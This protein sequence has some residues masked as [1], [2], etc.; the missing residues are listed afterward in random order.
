MAELGAPA[1]AGPSPAVRRRACDQRGGT[2]VHQQKEAKVIVST[3]ITSPSRP[4]HGNAAIPVLKGVRE[5]HDGPGVA[6]PLSRPA[7]APASV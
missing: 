4:L 2:V 6:L 7:A 5:N 1:V 3:V